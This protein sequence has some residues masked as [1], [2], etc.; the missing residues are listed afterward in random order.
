MEE[1]KANLIRALCDLLREA[2][3]E[4]VR[5]IFIAAAAMLGG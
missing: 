4:D 1:R 3:L 5:T 2:A